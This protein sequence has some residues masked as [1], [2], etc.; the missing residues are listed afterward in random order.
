MGHPRFKNRSEQTFATSS[1]ETSEFPSLRTRPPVVVI[2]QHQRHHLGACQKH[3]F[4]NL[5][6]TGPGNSR[7]GQHRPCDKPSRWLSTLT[8][9]NTNSNNNGVSLKAQVW[10]PAGPE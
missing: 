8:S 2:N 7:L 1:T 6:P 5:R 10:A 4:L 3:K 9:G